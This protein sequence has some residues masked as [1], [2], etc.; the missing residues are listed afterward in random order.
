MTTI[1]IVDIGLLFFDF[2]DLLDIVRPPPVQTCTGEIP[3]VCTV[4]GG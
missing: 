1:A 2:L 4:K 3:N